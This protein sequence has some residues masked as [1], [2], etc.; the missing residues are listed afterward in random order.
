MAHTDEADAD[1]YVHVD[2]PTS[3]PPR[4]A[5][6]SSLLQQL[7]RLYHFDIP[8]QGAVFKRVVVPVSVLLTVFLVM[9]AFYV[10]YNSHPTCTSE[11][12]D[13]FWSD[14][15]RESG[16]Y[17]VL[18]SA[19]GDW[20]ALTFY[21]P[22]A[23]T[24]YWTLP[25]ISSSTVDAAQRWLPTQCSTNLGEQSF[26]LVNIT[27]TAMP[28]KKLWVGVVAEFEHQPDLTMLIHG[29]AS[30]AV[31]P[32][33]GPGWVAFSAYPPY[34]NHDITIFGRTFTN[35]T[36][37]YN[38][39]SFYFGPLSAQAGIL[40]TAACVTFVT[41]IHEAIRTKCA[42]KQWFDILYLLGSAL[43]WLGGLHIVMG[44]VLRWT[45]S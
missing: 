45:T 41:Q 8:P 33:I 16:E 10:V 31:T 5:P 35:S 43:G 37:V 4:L 15:L 3:A 39:A 42:A 11:R 2:E 17:S 18:G 19:T 20:T 30:D 14:A 21:L 27:V 38:V 22:T 7:A 32:L 13:V 29:F 36:I 25:I 24:P 23:F 6:A 9:L 34:D 12:E 28:N 40:M 26:R 1:H 44:W